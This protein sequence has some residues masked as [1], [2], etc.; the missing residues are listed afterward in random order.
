[1]TAVLAAA[2]CDG[3][4]RL[5]GSADSGGDGFQYC[6][7][8]ILEAGEDC[9]SGDEVECTTSCGTLGTG[10]CTSDCTFPSDDECNPP[11]ENCGNGIDD[12]CQGGIERFSS[13]SD[14]M[15][16]SE[17]AMHEINA[18][19]ASSSSIHGGVLAIYTVETGWE[20]QEVHVAMVDTD[21]VRRQDINVNVIVSE[22]EDIASLSHPGIYADED[23][24]VLITALVSF[25]STAVKA[26]VLML[27]EENLEVSE[28]PML[29]YG[30]TPMLGSIDP[31]LLRTG[32]LVSILS[33]EQYMEGNA[34]ALR[35]LNV[36]SWELVS[37]RLYGEEHNYITSEIDA[38]VQDG[39][40][41]ICW[42]E[43]NSAEYQFKVGIID[44]TT[45][46][47]ESR[48]LDSHPSSTMHVSI[49]SV[50]ERVA[51]AWNRDSEVEIAILNTDSGITEVS[52]SSFTSA[53][54]PIYLAGIWFGHQYVLAV[55]H[56]TGVIEVHDTITL[57]SDSVF[58]SS[59]VNYATTVDDI[60]I[61]WSDG[62]ISVLA[63]SWLNS[64]VWHAYLSCQ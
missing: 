59:S 9:E 1:M 41:S 51:A 12:D 5:D 61:G 20:Q 29:I 32:G 56:G 62:Q 24:T 28:A 31:H 21:N 6:G 57:T 18:I 50:G 37:E 60:E 7:N 2:S 17:H 38:S 55:A 23:G 19:D 13:T 64:T 25:E 26:V 43:W 11:A 10:I 27:L 34:L 3:K 36:D 35:Q 8:G 40:M 49:A 39:V 33:I 42:T 54:V 45:G 22:Y 14:P 16:L 52:R 46:D 53:D 15:A 47:M 4:D 48:I 58:R 63:N 44:A 30:A